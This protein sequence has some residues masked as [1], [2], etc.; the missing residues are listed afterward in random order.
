MITLSLPISKVDLIIEPLQLFFAYKSSAELTILKLPFVSVDCAF[1]SL[2]KKGECNLRLS[3]TCV[4]PGI[5]LLKIMCVF[6]LFPLRKAFRALKSRMSLI[7]WPSQ[8]S[9]SSKQLQHQTILGKCT[10]WER[11][12]I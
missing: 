5:I 7:R 3:R 9:T 2:T 10:D 1:K 12:K 11:W 6:Q 8:Q 4:R